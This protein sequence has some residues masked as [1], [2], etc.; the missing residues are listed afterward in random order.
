MGLGNSPHR[1]SLY[2]IIIVII[3]IITATYIAQNC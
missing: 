3:I 2:I 1:N